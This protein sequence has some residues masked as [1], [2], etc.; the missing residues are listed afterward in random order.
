MLALACRLL[1][2]GSPRTLV[3]RPLA[4][5]ASEYAIA[6]DADATKRAISNAASLARANWSMPPDHGGAAVRLILEGAGLTSKW[7]DELASM[8]ARIAEVRA[9]LAAASNAVGVNLEPLG[10]QK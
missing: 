2:A 4:V 3:F 7:Q 10:R 1:Q 9:A 6:G 5:V 8:R